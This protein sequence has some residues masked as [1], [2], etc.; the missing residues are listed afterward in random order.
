MRSPK[1][2]LT[3]E[4]YRNYRGVRACAMANIVMGLLI[5]LPGITLPFALNSEK[6][7][8]P[9]GVLI[10]S[11]VFGGIIVLFGLA[12]IVGNIALLRGQRKW[13]MFVYITSMMWFCMFPVGTLVSIIFLNG[14]KR[15]YE[16]IDLLQAAETTDG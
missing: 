1:E 13:S 5:L 16:S 12:S 10:F 15:Y 9:R 7:A 4:E 14:L 11:L 6:A 3:P 2:I 8:N